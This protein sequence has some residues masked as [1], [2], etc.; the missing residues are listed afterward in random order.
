MH[1][2]ELELKFKP[3]IIVIKHGASIEQ[4]IKL[5]FKNGE[6]NAENRLPSRARQ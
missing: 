4:N 5:M 1:R 3:L 2:F 6:S